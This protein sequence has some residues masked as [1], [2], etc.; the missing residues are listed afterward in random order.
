MT[1]NCRCPMDMV[2]HF[3]LREGY[4]SQATIAIDVAAGKALAGRTL[5]IDC[6]TLQLLTRLCSSESWQRQEH[7]KH[8]G[9]LPTHPMAR[10]IQQ[11]CVAKKDLLDLSWF[12]FERFLIILKYF[13]VFPCDLLSRRETCS[14]TIYPCFSFQGFD[15]WST[16]VSK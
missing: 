3:K 7:R 2:S 8:H 12:T 6:H 16:K 1:L 5:A 13:I 4:C 14:I 15:A 9:E 10:N 11:R